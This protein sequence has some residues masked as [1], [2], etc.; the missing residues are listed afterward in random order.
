MRLSNIWIVVFF[1]VD[2]YSSMMHVTPS[3]LVTYVIDS[4]FD[5]QGSLQVH[6]DTPSESLFM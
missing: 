3:D 1:H 5:T 2:S 6:V 4:E